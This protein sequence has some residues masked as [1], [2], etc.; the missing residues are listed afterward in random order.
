[1]QKLSE[2]S[3]F[4]PAYNEEANLYSTVTKAIA[5]C[6]NI[7]DKYEIIIVDDGSRDKT[8]QIAKQLVNEDSNIRVIT[9]NPNQGYGGALKSGLY[10]A[11]Y[12]Y[13]AFTDSD[14][15]F[16][17]SQIERFI[18]HLEE[19]KMVVGYRTKRAEG[20]LRY[21]NAKLW[22]ILVN[23]LFAVNIKDIDCAFKVFHKEIID[24]IPQLESYGALI[25]TE[26]LVKTRKKGYKIKQ[27][28]VDHY[29]RIGGKSTGANIKVIL[30]A[31]FELFKLWRKLK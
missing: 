21:L 23:L 19:Y 11:K 15:Q 31:F 9:H 29:L 12:Q 2:L 7:S 27:V 25:S 17:F 8:P 24:N 28:P 6:K 30:K 22:G 4:F 16:D 18:P 3:V 5:V 1:M 20:L 13:I 14:G 26:L 10:S